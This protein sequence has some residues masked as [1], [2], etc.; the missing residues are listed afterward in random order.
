MVSEKG[1]CLMKLF[2]MSIMSLFLIEMCFALGVSPAKVEA[3]FQPDLTTTISYSVY[4]KDPNMELELYVGGDLAEYV[5]LNKKKLVGGGSFTVTIK[6]PHSIEKPGQ[7]KIYVGVREMVDEELVGSAIGTSVTIQSVIIIYVPYPGKYLEMSLKSHNV[8]VGGVVDFEL[9]VVSYGEEDIVISPKIDIVSDN[10]T[11]QTLLFNERLLKSR[12]SFKLHK[13]LDTFG[14]NPGRYKATAFIIY[15]RIA[16]AETNF[17]IG[18][19]SIDILNH[20]RQIVI[21]RLKKFE[22]EIESGWNNKI[23]G[24][25]AEV[26]ISN[27][28]GKLMSFKTSSTSLTPWEKKTISG[29]FDTTY[30]EKGVYDANI[31]VKYYGKDVGRSSS[32]LVQIEFVEVVNKMLRGL[33]IGAAVILLLLL[34]LLI[35]ISLSKRNGKKK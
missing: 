31:T 22:I 29:F 23:D 12:E 14:Y 11:I 26:F 9:D 3:N 19:L 8:N 27:S 24:A 2:F 21:G 25:Y 16:K 30:F 28:S 6:L 4:S 13:I 15:N 17:K 35:K 33:I 5:Q 7:H 1:V 10:E 18:H 34:G 20:T 32:R